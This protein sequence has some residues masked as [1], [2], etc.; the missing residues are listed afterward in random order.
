MAPTGVESVETTPTM[1]MTAMATED[2]EVDGDDGDDDGESDLDGHSHFLPWLHEA[3]NAGETDKSY[4]K[5][6][7]NENYRQIVIY[8]D[9][10]RLSGF[11]GQCKQARRL[12]NWMHRQFKR[13]NVPKDEQVKLDVL[14][15]Y[16]DDTPQIQ[17]EDE[18]WNSLCDQLESYKEECHTFVISKKDHLHKKLSDWKNHQRKLHRKG[19][20]RPDRR[21]K[22]V[23]I[24][25][26]K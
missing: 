9:K 20:L 5:R 15:K 6:V 21:Q 24:G 8:I 12:S 2:E 13:K 11:P 18:R 25:F 4:R 17:K 3:K 22:L 1:T 16:F 23:E 7:F 10:G 19:K 26:L 14:R